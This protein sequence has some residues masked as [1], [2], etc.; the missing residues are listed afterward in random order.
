MENA[1]SPE[2]LEKI[3]NQ[4][5]EN[6]RRTAHVP[7][8]QMQD[9]PRHSM[10]AM[11]DEDDAELDDLDEDENK[12]VRMTQRQ[13]EQRIERD[14]EYDVSDNEDME[15]ANGVHRNG[16]SRRAFQDY[17]NSDM[18]GDSGV[19]TPANGSAETVIKSKETDE[20]V[21]KDAEE[22]MEETTVKTSE[23]VVEPKNG[24]NTVKRETAAPAAAEKE[25]PVAESKEVP[26]PAKNGDKTEKAAATSPTPAGKPDQASKEDDEVMQD[27]E[28]GPK[29]N[30][31]EKEKKENA[32]TESIKSPK[33]HNIDKDGDITMD[34]P[35]TDQ[36][37][38]DGKTDK[39]EE[40]VE[41]PLPAEATENPKDPTSS[42]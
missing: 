4:L 36:K 2:Y 18:E 12:D 7:S 38:N 14:D 11:T 3:K 20:V 9:V 15:K 10:G 1:N 32:A 37:P 16:T 22:V 35:P 23:T 34:E 17:R 27:V 40:S 19:A 39:P 33:E 24:E 5:I 42:S 30:E 41:T 25:E 28:D 21:M 8:V 31:K 26:K 13:W 6:L 29:Q